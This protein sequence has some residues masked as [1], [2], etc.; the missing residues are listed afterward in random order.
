MESELPT[1]SSNKLWINKTDEQRVMVKQ[2]KAGEC[3]R[4]SDKSL[5]Q[6]H[7]IHHE[8]SHMWL[9]SRFCSDKPVT[10]LL[11]YNQIKLIGF[12]NVSKLI[13][14]QNKEIKIYF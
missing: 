1:V 12:R 13:Q 9:S 10:N 7:F 3:W 4:N 11:S 6:W 2:W 8:W 14:W 5:L